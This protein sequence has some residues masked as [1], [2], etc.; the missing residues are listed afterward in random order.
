MVDLRAQVA[1]GARLEWLPQETLVRRGAIAQN[2]MTFELEPL[3]EMIG[4]DVLGLGLPASGED[5]DSGSVTQTI[6]V[7]RFWLEH[8]AIDNA[9][10]NA[11]AEL[12]AGFHR[13]AATGAGV[14]EFGTPAGIAVSVE[15]NFDQLAPFV[16]RASENG[17]GRRGILTSSQHTF[18]R[19]R[20]RAFLVKQRE[21]LLR[22][23]AAGRI[24]EG[25]GDLHTENVCQMPAGFVIY[26]RIEFNR[27]LRCLDVANDL[28]FLA[29]DLDRRGFPGFAGYLARIYREQTND[30]ELALVFDFY[31]GYRALVRAKVAALSTRRAALAASAR[32]EL[33]RESMRYLQLALG[34]EL[35]PTLVLLS[36]LPA[37]GKTTLAPHLAR[38]LRAAQFHSDERRKQLAGMAAETSARAD[39]GRGLY[40]EAAKQQTYRALLDDTLRALGGGRSVVV[41]ATF[42][43]REYRRPFIEAAT[44]MG[45]PYCFV[46]VG[47]PEAVVRERMAARV[48]R[49]ASDADFGTYLRARTAF[50]PLEEVP[51]GHVLDVDSTEGAPEDQASRLFDR[52]IALETD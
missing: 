31:K 23:V 19:L 45:L 36:G 13:A 34:Y 18:L 5:F 48:G 35:G 4:W 44:R 1:D 24:R 40:S 25:H 38:P 41:D 9:Q 26:D 52:L 12:L 10:M 33:Q 21:L 2:R 7:N 11:L 16:I 42:A 29:M 39:W 3:A 28:A 6:Q 14:D 17:R 49:G 51:G 46:R 32:E 43:Q 37:S 22:R 27:R 8:G 47:A 50:E 15:E 20:A 30:P